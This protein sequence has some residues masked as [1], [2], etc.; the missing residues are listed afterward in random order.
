MRATCHDVLESERKLGARAL[1]PVVGP[2]E[3]AKPRITL[4]A[5]TTAGAFA[6]LKD[7]NAKRREAR[8]REAIFLSFVFGSTA[9]L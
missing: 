1:E 5:K 7:V 2:A 9:A 6:E 3:E 4:G 8:A